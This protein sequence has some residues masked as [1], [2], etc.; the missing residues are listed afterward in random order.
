MM[1]SNIETVRRMVDDARRARKL[2]FD[3][4]VSDV[5]T[6]ISSFKPEALP[7]LDAY[8]RE[9]Q[10]AA[11][12]ATKLSEKTTSHAGYEDARAIGWYVPH[13]HPGG[14]WDGLRG[15]M[16]SSGLSGA[17]DS[18]DE[19]ADA[20]M[21]HLAQP[22]VKNDKRRG[23]VIGNV[24]S[25][26]TANY[27]AVAAK[28][29]DEG[30]KFVIVM[31]GIHSNLRQQTQQRLERDL[32]TQIDKEDWHRLTSLDGD[33]GRADIKNAS[34]IVSK[35]ERIL[36]VVKKNS[37]RLKNLV[38]FIQAVDSATLANTP[39][40]I[41]DDESDQATP[42]SS[43]SKEAEPTAIN[44]R[45]KEI[46][47][48]VGNG[49]YVGYTA[50]PFANVFMDPNDDT[51]LY[52]A[53]FVSVLPTP[54]AYFGAE[55][56]FGLSQDSSAR[57]SDLIRHIDD[58]EIEYLVPA[59]GK[60]ASPF[61]PRVTS[62]LEVAVK[63]FVVAAAVRRLRGQ[64]AE[65]STM[66]VHTTH[67]VDPH[68]AMRDEIQSFLQP[69][70]K[71]AL[72]GDVDSFYEVFHDE[73]NRAAELYTGN[74]P[75]PA[76]PEVSTEIRSV[77]RTLDVAVDNGSADDEDRL[78]YTGDKPKTVI[79]IGGGTL[80]RGLTLEGLFVSFFC[81]T[82]NAYD[83]LLQMGRWFGY[84][85]GYED[86]QRVW[87]SSRLDSDYRFLATIEAD[88]R[89]E[90]D[91]MTAAH[92]TPRQ[93]GLR[94]RQHPGRLE[95]TSKNKMKHVVNVQVDFESFQL[96]TT[97]F[98][99]RELEQSNEPVRDFLKSLSGHRFAGSTGNS[100]LYKDVSAS[101][102]TEFL[103]NF[104]VHQSYADLL[105]GAIDWSEHK[106]PD[107]AWNVVLSNGS[108]Q[109]KFSVGDVTVN[110]VKRGPLRIGK[111]TR[112]DAEIDIRA[113]MSAGD[114]I[115]DL[116]IEAVSFGAKPEKMKNDAQKDLRKSP[117]GASGRGLLVL[118]PISRSS[119]DSSETRQPM[120]DALSAIN[121]EL[122]SEEPL[123]GIGLVAP[124]DTMN[125]L[126]DKGDY[127]AVQPNYTDDEE[128]LEEPPTDDE[129]DF[130]G[131]DVQ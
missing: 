8:V 26:K 75:A 15:R 92:R 50:T 60:N 12:K 97:R 31:S 39:I 30:Y 14:V 4:A 124:S 123:F 72:D 11:Q 57:V 77:L 47:Q 121:P 116:N 115:A 93:I 52:P 83:T 99:F 42:D 23:L 85:Q 91:K 78:D 13:V 106:L 54:R 102:V 89:S 112:A 66:L 7:D 63:W 67:R 114:L 119:T 58:N 36:A 65:H 103:R 109:E 88:L 41:I 101:R 24:Q 28:A 111:S 46:W 16:R 33:I 49:T 19:A 96:Q 20:V 43:A 40:L 59:S 126:K 81:R 2:S 56:L 118:Y 130:G 71:A 53:D 80:S 70:R 9:H 90:I 100:V 76:W 87:V 122:V 95:I 127:V 125:I 79:V 94:I 51:D 74:S 64:S 34:G 1:S 62:S 113:L 27:A 120:I 69:L 5:R 61:E 68:F 38:D 110:T 108:G 18:I 107:T 86:L 105:R 84:R 44:Q 29:L 10:D 35:S 17:V 98:N 25:G 45:M 21:S 117:E 131:D 48:L 32:G 55:K 22:M 82:S 3:D 37:R 104:N 6:L 73:M 129:K 128:V